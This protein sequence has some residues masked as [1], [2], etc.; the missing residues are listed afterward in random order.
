MILLLDGARKAGYSTDDI[1]RAA[2]AKMEINYRRK[3]QAPDADG[4][5]R[6]VKDDA[7]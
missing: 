4:V 6:H 3:W 5:V 7:A 2:L 1:Y